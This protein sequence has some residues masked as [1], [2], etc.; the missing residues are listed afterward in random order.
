[1][2]LGLSAP[3]GRTV[4]WVTPQ[5]GGLEIEVVLHTAR[6]PG[7]LRRV[8]RFTA[9]D[10]ARDRAKAAAFTLAAMVRERDAD[11]KALE[12]P[13]P[14]VVTLPAPPAQ[15]PW[16]LEASAVLGFN[17]PNVHA[18]GGRAGGAAPRAERRGC[19]WAWASRWVSTAHRPPRW[20]SPRS[21]SRAR[22][23]CCAGRFR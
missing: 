17:V 9:E 3:P 1:M 8:L 21:T 2:G 22:C 23:R 7:D 16:L 6:I 13:R 12:T 5:A 4:A 11:L 15:T 19:S 20:C 14:E 10:A 18:G